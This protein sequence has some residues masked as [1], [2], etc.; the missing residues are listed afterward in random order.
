MLDPCGL[1]RLFAAALVPASL[2][3]GQMGGRALLRTL[4]NEGKDL[5]SQ[6][7]LDQAMTTCW[8]KNVVRAAQMPGSTCREGRSKQPICALTA[9]VD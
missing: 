4:P 1:A 6:E 9:C 7:T 3:L 5:Q 8:M 2:K